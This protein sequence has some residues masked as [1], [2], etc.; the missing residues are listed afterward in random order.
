VATEA[1]AITNGAPQQTKLHPT[2]HAVERVYPNTTMRTSCDRTEAHNVAA[3]DPKTTRNPCTAQRKFD[4]PDALSIAEVHS[5][6]AGGRKSVNIHREFRI[7]TE[8]AT[9]VFCILA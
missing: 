6:L 5:V 2:V 3:Y 1:T 9:E 7:A 8:T 4:V